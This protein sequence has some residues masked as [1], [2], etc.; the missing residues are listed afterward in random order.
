MR[1]ALVCGAGGFIG[2]LAEKGLEK[3]HAPGPLGV[4]GRNSDNRLFG[5]N[6]V[7]RHPSRSK[8]ACALP[9]RGSSGKRVRMPHGQSRSAMANTIVE[10]RT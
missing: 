10:H 6:S 3:R 7:G 2:R 8:P 5:K 9:T 4:R 1:A